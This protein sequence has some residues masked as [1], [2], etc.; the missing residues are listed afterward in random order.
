MIAEF[1]IE[2]FFS[3]KSPQ[4]ISFEPSS[5]TFLSD[6]YTYEVKERVRLLK[7]GIIY[8]ANASGK[9][10]IL[11]AIE[12]F[13]KLVLIMPQNRNEKTG[14]VPFMLDDT[15]RNENTKMSM[16][17]YI[18]RSK[19]ILSFELDAKR[20]YSETLIVYDSIRPTKLYSRSYDAATDSTIIDFGSN[21][22]MTRKSQDVISGNTINNCSVLAA[23]GKSNV[24]RTRLNDVYDYFAKQVKKVLAPGM[25][26]SRYVKSRLS[27][28]EAGDLKKF[29][30]NFLKASDFNIE[31]VT[32]HEEEELITPELEQ[33]IKN[34][35]I[36]KEAKA[37]MLRKGKII[38][39]EL[40][41]KHKAGDNVYDLSEK[42]ESNGTMRFLGMAVILNYLLKTN[43]FVP[44]D[45]VETSIH[46]ELLAYF[47]KVFLANS[48]G[49]S[50]M[51][52]TTHD[53]NLLNE[54]FIRRDTIWFT[55]KDEL[56]E[57]KIVR[58]SSLGLHKNLS[59]YNAYK[60]G[61]LVKLPFL[62]SQYINLND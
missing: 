2:N 8:G 57:T 32:L 59:P 48:D 30:L 9:T 33:L 55:D 26:L 49:T 47:L 6:E 16:V 43:R 40:T 44:I 60:Q 11:N 52:L 53:I 38:N 50:Q 12:F 23:F 61:K 46:Y 1:S 54:D 3:I 42:Y 36:D 39:T 24:E 51:L 19:Y 62:G 29:I 18:N 45:E 41:F 7:I 17:F 14:V 21:L 58:L 27:K 15:S 10:N 56:G 28:D 31:D 22:K 20:I 4:K 35:P 25:L 13:S 34:V 37:E 5:D